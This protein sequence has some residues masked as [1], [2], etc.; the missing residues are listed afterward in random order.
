[1]IRA[2]RTALESWPRMTQM[3]TTTAIVS[4]ADVTAQRMEGV[5]SWDAARTGRLAFYGGCI[6]AP[7]F[8]VWFQLMHQ[9]GPSNL[10]AK[11]AC[12]Q[13]I[14][15]P[16][17]ITAAFTSNALLS[18]RSLDDA[19]ATVRERLFA[20]WG[21]SMM[22]WGSIALVNYSFV[23]LQFRVLFLNFGSF[24]WNIHISRATTAAK[25]A[26]EEADASAAAAGAC[27]EEAGVAA[28]HGSGAASECEK[29]V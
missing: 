16:T 12:E 1:M 27:V 21:N 4:A 18:G 10:L 24:G 7:V 17:M 9:H 14:M 28:A 3:L 15:S 19:L 13:A 6:V 29:K 8:R 5:Q 22:W 2:Y 11:V 26:R 25:E 23:P 20:T